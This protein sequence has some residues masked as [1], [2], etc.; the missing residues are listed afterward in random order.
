MAVVTT[1]TA[2]VLLVLGNAETALPLASD[3][4][5]RFRGIGNPQHLAGATYIEGAA[6]A[7]VGRLTQA[8]AL[9]RESLALYY[10]MEDWIDIVY[11]VEAIARLFAEGGDAAFAARLLGGVEVI[12]EQEQV[13]AYPLFDAA[14]T[15][16]AIRAALGSE[17]MHAQW[18]EGRRLDRENVVAEALLVGAIADGDPVDVLIVR[19]A[20]PSVARRDDSLTAR[21]IDVLR[22][23]AAGKS[24]R[25][26]GQA[27]A[28]SDRT[29]ER[30]LTAIFTVLDVDRRSAAV[31][32][33]TAAGLLRGPDL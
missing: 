3:A 6:L 33:A 28:I 2:E 15:I 32:K 4:V 17:A 26:I 13:A 10:E 30:H 23:V 27:L 24:N 31:A 5:T 22:L 19:R 9:F 29:V 11:A 14:G 1:N 20:Q 16:A 8:L 12:R 25:E 21:Q 7:A 18:E